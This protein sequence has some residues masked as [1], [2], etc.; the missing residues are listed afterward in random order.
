MRF[1]VEGMS[2]G[3]CVRAVSEAVARLGG[4][5]QVDLPNG[6]VEVS[7]IRDAEAVRRAIEAEGYQVRASFPDGDGG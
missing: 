7:G 5:A 2:C 1:E 3:H 6:Q 4:V